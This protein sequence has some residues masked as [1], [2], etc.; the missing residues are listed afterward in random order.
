MPEKRKLVLHPT[1]RF[2]AVPVPPGSDQA[3]EE[4]PLQRHLASLERICGN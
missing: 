1:G 2:L 4:T 3:A